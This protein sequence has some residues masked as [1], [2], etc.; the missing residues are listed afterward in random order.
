MVV[1]SVLPVRTVI[2]RRICFPSPQ[3]LCLR[4]QLSA[5]APN[6]CILSKA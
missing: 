1:A 6:F 5:Y 3:Y 2:F 4:D